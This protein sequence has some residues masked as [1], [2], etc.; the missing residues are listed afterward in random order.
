[1]AAT[2]QKE[3]IFAVNAL[4]TTRRPGMT[5]HGSDGRGAAANAPGTAP[6]QVGEAPGGLGAKVTVAAGVEHHRDD[7][8]RSGAAGPAAAPTSAGG[9]TGDA[10]PATIIRASAKLAPA[11]RQPWRTPQGPRET[12]GARPWPWGVR[13]A[14]R[15]RRERGGP[16]VPR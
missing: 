12:A 7:D 6:T 13:G 8:S 5:P 11:P 16:P 1:M 3:R 2:R 9:R 15:R 10:E 4:G 14:A